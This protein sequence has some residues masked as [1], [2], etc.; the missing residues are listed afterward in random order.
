M[1]WYRKS[2]KEYDK[3]KDGEYYVPDAIKPKI[4]SPHGF[5]NFKTESKWVPV[6]SSFISE[7]AYNKS[8]KIFEIRL[9]NG[10]EYSY[11][12]IPQSVYRN[13][14]RAKS[15]GEFFN[16]VIK[17]RYLFIANRNLL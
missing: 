10:S 5:K 4:T 8:L 6:N 9:R 15:K 12:G 7:V 14:M 1:N 16:R 17:N 11:K 13:F 2:I 3:I